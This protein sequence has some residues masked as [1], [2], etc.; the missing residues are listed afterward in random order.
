MWPYGR[1]PNAEMV[2]CEL[3]QPRGPADRHCQ[4]A[5][6][7]AFDTEPG[8][9]KCDEQNDDTERRGK[10][11]QTT[12]LVAGDRQERRDGPDRGL[13]ELSKRKHNEGGIAGLELF[14]ENA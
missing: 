5:C 6:S 3:V 11:G 2:A 4:H 9:E 14:S 10:S 13:H 1:G 7:G 8:Y 12:T